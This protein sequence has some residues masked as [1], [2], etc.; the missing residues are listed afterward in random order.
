MNFQ[1]INTS[2]KENIPLLPANS[3]QH[4]LQVIAA[5]EIVF[6]AAINCPAG[7]EDSD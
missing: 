4:I 1:C 6:S 2:N 5:Q 3:C 7:E